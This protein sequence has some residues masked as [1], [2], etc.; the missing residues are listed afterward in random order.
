M[1]RRGWRSCSAWTQRAARVGAVLVALA[2]AGGRSV[3]LS[4]FDREEPP[5]LTVFLVRHA[6]AYRNVPGWLRPR[7]LSEQQ[8]DSLTPR[9]ETQ[10]AALGRALAAE[11][12]SLVLS[13]PAGR[14]RQT[15]AAI[16]SAVGA[17]E[18]RV[19]PAL[20]SLRGGQ[21]PQGEP[22][23]YA[24]RE[25]QWESGADPR[26]AGGESLGDG[27]TR[28]RELIERLAA[29]Q[30]G[31]RVA[32]VSHGEVVAALLGHAQGTPLLVRPAEHDVA[33]GSFSVLTLYAAP[34]WRL[35][36]EGLRP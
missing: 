22:A 17:G 3:P 36:S 2:C 13:S 35:E 7:D 24:W 19:E 27:L 9:G 18:P 25:E 32:L 34:R 29:E 15:A 1:V 31:A 4:E 28:A 20:G 12:I 14:A 23:S 8:L 26:P 6:Q 16:A 21:T 11:R 5:Q 30:P 10:A 33:A